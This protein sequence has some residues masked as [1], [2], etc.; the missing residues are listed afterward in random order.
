M[1]VLPPED[2]NNSRNL[3]TITE[4]DNNNTDNT[5]SRFSSITHES[6]KDNTKTNQNKNKTQD[7]SPDKRGIK[8]LDE[9][10][11]QVKNAEPESSVVTAESFSPNVSPAK[12]KNSAMSDPAERPS[13][14]IETK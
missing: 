11:P 1:V 6:N 3:N 4:H 13:L 5:N 12:L 7:N 8:P 10:P 14:K 9:L 2:N